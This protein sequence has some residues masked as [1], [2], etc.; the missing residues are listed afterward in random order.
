MFFIFLFTFTPPNA[1][2]VMPAMDSFSLALPMM[3]VW[4]LAKTLLPATPL[5]CSA[6]LAMMALADLRLGG[7]FCCLCS[8]L[9]F[10]LGEVR[11][12][13]KKGHFV[14]IQL[15]AELIWISQEP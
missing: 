10:V 11:M 14:G 6:A 5:P 13:C 1:H 9:R 3:S 15:R 4:Y 7:T 12:N 8:V 2:L